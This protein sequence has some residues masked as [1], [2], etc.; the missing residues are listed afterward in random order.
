MLKINP[1]HIDGKTYNDLTSKHGC[2]QFDD[3]GCCEWCRVGIDDKCECAELEGK[4]LRVM[5]ASIKPEYKSIY[6]EGIEQFA[7][8]SDHV[9]PFV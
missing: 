8:S 2:R 9:E 5:I 1:D 7:L 4:Q 3:H 6:K